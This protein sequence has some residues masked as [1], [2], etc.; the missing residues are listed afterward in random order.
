MAYDQEEIVLLRTELG[1]LLN[2]LDN[3]AASENQTGE[4]RLKKLEEKNIQLQ[5]ELS[6][7][8][9]ENDLLRS[10]EQLQIQLEREKFER[11]LSE[12]R[13]EQELIF[14]TLES[15]KTEKENLLETNQ[16]LVLD[17]EGTHTLVGSQARIL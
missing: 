15:L 12:I 6:Q 7:V 5:N 13:S 2:C 1:K 11:K 10:Q 14:Q 16:K 4:D 9:S 8:K 3:I 17:N